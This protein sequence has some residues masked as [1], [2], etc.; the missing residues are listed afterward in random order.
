MIN[1]TLSASSERINQTAGFA[2]K[3][4]QPAAIEFVPVGDM[5]DFDYQTSLSTIYS[6]PDLR[7]HKPKIRDREIR[8]IRENESEI[9]CVQAKPFG[10]S[11]GVLFDA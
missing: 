6:T 10:E 3:S 9:G 4:A 2:R 7:I 8:D 1:V 5:L 11:S